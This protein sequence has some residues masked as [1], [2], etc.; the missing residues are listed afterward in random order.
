MKIV[1]EQLAELKEID[2]IKFII[3]Y[4]LE[5]VEKAIETKS[6]KDNIGYG[7]NI[8]ERDAY[9]RMLKELTNI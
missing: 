3:Q 7:Y 5:Q 9:K 1:T 2:R 4:N 6:H 8:G